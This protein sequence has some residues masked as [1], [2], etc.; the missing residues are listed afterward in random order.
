MSFG[1]RGG[2]A[3]V[4]SLQTITRLVAEAGLATPALTERDWTTYSHVTATDEELAAIQEPIAAYFAGRTMAE[5]Y[6]VACET[7]LM[8]APANTPPQIYDSAQLAAREMFGPLGEH[9]RFPL[10]FALARGADGSRVPATA[11]GPAPAAHTQHCRPLGK[12]RRTRPTPRAAPAARPSFD[13]P[14][15][16]PEMR[17]ARPRPTAP[18]RGRDWTSC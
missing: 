2:K 5:L 12:W 4:P 6:Q 15:R 1:L 18:P 7:N 13:L 11:R 16:T 9:G 10:R 8:L 3:R 14:A 17:P